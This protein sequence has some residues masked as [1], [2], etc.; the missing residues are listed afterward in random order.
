MKSFLLLLSVFFLTISIQAQHTKRYTYLLVRINEIKVKKDV[1]Y[2][3]TAEPGNKYAS[4][5]YGLL[6]FKPGIYSLDQPAFYQVRS[7]TS[8]VF[9]NCFL[10]TTEALNFLSERSWELVSVTTDIS[11]GWYNSSGGAVT[12][13]YSN[14]V[15]YFRKE[16]N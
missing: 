15:Y 5:I 16:L 3:I 12:T 13:I 14:P 7:D 6:P 8:T 2:T 10:N 9:Y 4:A 11:S 1:Y